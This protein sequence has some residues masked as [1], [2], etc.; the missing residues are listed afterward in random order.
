MVCRQRVLELLP[1]V[2]GMVSAMARSEKKLLH[3]QEKRQKELWNL[4]KVACVCILVILLL[5]Y[6]CVHMHNAVCLTWACVFQSKVRSPVSGSPDGGRTPPTAA[7]PLMSH[8]PSDVPQTWVQLQGMR[9]FVFICMFP[10]W[11]SLS[12]VFRDDS[13]LVIEESKM[14]EGRLQ[15]LVHDTIQETETSMQ[16]I[17]FRLFESY[18]L[19]NFKFSKN[20]I[21]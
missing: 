3:L 9:H 20:E 2:E 16:V 21:C 17:L 10:S 6:A 5:Q 19:L 15:S 13:Q 11:V 4:L 18:L 7:L 8:R 14:F 12:C 1:R